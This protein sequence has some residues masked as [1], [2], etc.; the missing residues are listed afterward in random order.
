M[1]VVADTIPEQ[2]RGQWVGV[3]MGGYA[4]GFIFGPAMG[5]V[6]FERW[7]YVAPFALSAGLAAAGLLVALMMVPETRTTAT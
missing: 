3:I 1:G 6:L 7:G 2:K 4:V 5:G